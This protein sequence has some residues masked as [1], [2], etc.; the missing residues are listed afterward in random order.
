VGVSRRFPGL[1]RKKK[2]VQKN[3]RKSKEG[4]SHEMLGETRKRGSLT[5]PVSHNRLQP[6]TP[7]TV[8]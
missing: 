8:K 3:Q 2:K 6:P 1:R 5:I 7:Y 4:D